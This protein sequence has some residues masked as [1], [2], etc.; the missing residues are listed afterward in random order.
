VLW[1]NPSGSKLIVV[2]HRPGANAITHNTASYHIEIGVLTGN[3]FAPL[4]GAPSA[5]TPNGWPVF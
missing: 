5:S 2:A 4:H 3:K 1:T